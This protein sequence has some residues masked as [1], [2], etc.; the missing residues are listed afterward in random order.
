[1]ASVVVDGIR[2]SPRAALREVDKAAEFCLMD[3]SCGHANA[4]YHGAVR[5]FSLAAKCLD[6]GDIGIRMKLQVRKD[7]LQVTP[8]PFW[9]R[10]LEGLGRAARESH[11]PAARLERLAL[12]TGRAL[13]INAPP[14][15]VV[16]LAELGRVEV[17][18][19]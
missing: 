8:P 16:R 10:T 15:S 18:I 17:A 5:A 2:V 14:W 6:S 7:V 9:P 4:A 12:E 1:M 3:V 13:G 19:Q 11:W